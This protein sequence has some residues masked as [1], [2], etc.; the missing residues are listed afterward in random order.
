MKEDQH[1]REK[2]LHVRPLSKI[3]VTFLSILTIP[4]FYTMKNL[5]LWDCNGQSF[6]FCYSVLLLWI[7]ANPF[8]LL[9]QQ[10]PVPRQFVSYSWSSSEFAKLK[11][12][13]NEHIIEI[14]SA[15]SLRIY[16]SE[17]KL[18]FG[19]YILL[20]SLEDGGTQRLS[21][22]MLAQWENS[23]AYFNGNKVS[24]SLVKPGTDTNS[25]FK[26]TQVEID[27]IVETQTWGCASLED[28]VHSNDA[29]IGRILPLGCTGFIIKNGKIVTSGPCASNN[30]RVIEFNVPASNSNGTIRHPGP[31]HQ[32]IVK[33]GSVKQG[34]LWAVFEVD[35]NAV[36]GLLPLDA[37]GKSLN[38]A[39]VTSAQTI[40]ITGYGADNGARN[41]TQQTHAGPSFLFAGVE[42][43]Y[44]TA[45]AIGN[46]GSPI[47][48]ESTGNAIGVHTTEE[49]TSGGVNIGISA[50]LQ[51]FWDAMGLDGTTPQVGATLYQH[52]AYGGYA[53]SL[54]AGHYTRAALQARGV[55]D[56]DISSLRVNPGYR[57]TLFDGDNSTGSFIIKSANDDC[58]VNDSFNDKTTYVRVDRTSSTNARSSETFKVYPNPSRGTL[59]ITEGSKANHIQLI[60]SEGTLVK[61]W[62]T[63]HR[64]TIDVSGVQPGT[65]W[66]RVSGK[67]DKRIEKIV[68]E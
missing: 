21:A 43:S 51:E 56:N 67:D 19:S 34:F 49:C 57:V 3:L 58:L 36:T 31:E 62:N 40:R 13:S 17:V 27:K 29:A 24:V 8:M 2:K 46:E 42:I 5:N 1:V 50:T 47:I 4:K 16:F 30:A 35:P 39:R 63:I 12:V 9:A 59:N 53:V 55:K 61:S 41:L 37:Q 66:I 54:E 38:V 44:L 60:N 45:T 68:I 7:M 26:I 28:R 20:T 65:Y 52:C 15:A 22:A 48:D 33:A 64:S 32:Y 23:S 14:P 25:S 18:S 10:L 6:R 11:S